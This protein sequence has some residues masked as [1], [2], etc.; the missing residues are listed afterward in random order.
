MILKFKYPSFREKLWTEEMAQSL[1]G[2]TFTAKLEEIPIGEGKI[3]DAVARKDGSFVDLMV[4]WP[5]DE[6]S[7]G[8][9]TSAPDL[10][11]LSI[12]KK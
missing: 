8:I 9:L 10:K 4:E 11:Y 12:G 1:I 3:I 2:K 5:D 7:K 6:L